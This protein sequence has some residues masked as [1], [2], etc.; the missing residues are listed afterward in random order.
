MGLDADSGRQIASHYVGPTARPAVL[1]GDG[2]V[3]VATENLELIGYDPTQEIETIREPLVVDPIAN[4]VEEAGVLFVAG[5]DGTVRAYT[6]GGEVEL[7][8][9]PPAST[10]IDGPISAVAW[11]TGGELAFVRRGDV[12]VVGR[13]GDDPVNLTRPSG[14]G[15]APA[16]SPDG[17]WLAY[18]SGSVGSDVYLI[19]P[20]GTGRRNLTVTP[21]TDEHDPAWS[22][23]GSRIVFSS[24]DCVD[25]GGPQGERV[26]LGISELKTVDLSGR[27]RPV[28]G[29]PT[30]FA[31]DRDPDWSPAGNLIAFVSDRSVGGVPFGA[32]WH[33]WTIATD[34]ADLTPLVGRDAA[35]GHSPAFSPDGS[36]LAYFSGGGPAGGEA[37][38]VIDLDSGASSRLTD[39]PIGAGAPAWSPDGAELA[40]T[41]DR[42]ALGRIYTVSTDG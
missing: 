18:T 35:V 22:P 4:P 30:V 39:L 42:A 13:D 24:Q 16:W 12:W 34:G 1:G 9:S 11:S 32:E 21:S 8:S 41:W 6:G 37:I 36:R 19:H 29:N 26:C 23:D 31:S 10:S 14:G 28:I 17:G 3:Y 20:D 25:E 2:N 7:E 33:L 15:S 27:I 5:V 38:F 40:F